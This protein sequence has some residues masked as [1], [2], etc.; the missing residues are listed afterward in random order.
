M[1]SWGETRVR[2]TKAHHITPQT[3]GMR[4]EKSDTKMLL[5]LV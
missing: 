5:S 2:M 4:V 3:L 1:G